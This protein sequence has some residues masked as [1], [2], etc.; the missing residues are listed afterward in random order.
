[1]AVGRRNWWVDHLAGLVTTIVGAVV[2]A[3]IVTVLIPA[4]QNDGNDAPADAPTE[5]E[6]PAVE[7]APAD[8]GAG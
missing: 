2:A 4:I 5:V 1:M 8:E 7:E 6:A 3:I